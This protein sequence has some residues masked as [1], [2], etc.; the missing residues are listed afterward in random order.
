MIDS[1]SSAT[2]MNASEFEVQLRRRVPAADV[3]LD[4]P[5]NVAGAWF[6]D[7][8]TT[9][10]ALVIEGRPGSGIGLSE[11]RDEPLYG[12]A[13]P[14]EFFRDHHRALDRAA[15]LLRPSAE[16]A[17]H[18]LQVQSR[19]HDLRNV[20]A[21]IRSSSE[22]LLRVE[23]HRTDAHAIL[24]AAVAGDMLAQKLLAPRES[25]IRPS[26]T[27]DERIRSLS[28][29]VQRLLGPSMTLELKLN[30]SVETEG[31]GG[32]FE[33]AIINLVVNARDAMT[34]GGTLEI[35]TSASTHDVIVTVADTGSGIPDELKERIFEPFFTTK[36]SGRG[37]GL[38]T[39]KS[40]VRSA[41]G[42]VD[43]ESSSKGT[44]FQL[45]LPRR[46]LASPQTETV[47]IVDDDDAMRAS[48]ARALTSAGFHV[49]T[50]AG[51]AEAVTTL[52]ARPDVGVAVLDVNLPDMNGFE[53]AQKLEAD[54]KRLGVIFMS[55]AVEAR[56]QADIRAKPFLAKPF[57]NEEL[58]R[59][60]RSAGKAA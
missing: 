43:V 32:A 18:I 48:L 42:R 13:L 15:E 25:S 54:G 40:F 39:V 4:E 5:R 28:H 6:I 23:P 58:A 27:P 22:E 55:G 2:M 9:E 8:K 17:E 36:D 10:R 46:V 52:R 26:F 47:L 49:L 3:T 50:A 24:Q 51:G 35:A 37:L 19:A 34:E 1:T 20:F 7:A 45:T 44:T 16:L 31:D 57:S 12:E 30:A 29:L 38:P 60:V 33:Q 53:L 14:D 21:A 41:G 59:R 11:V 56:V